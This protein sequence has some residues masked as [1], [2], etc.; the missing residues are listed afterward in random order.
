MEIFDSINLYLLNHPI[1]IDQLE[2]AIR[3]KFW[4]FLVLALFFLSLP[5]R[6]QR[7]RVKEQAELSKKTDRFL[8]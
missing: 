5:Y 4:V 7:K 1:M 3:I 6:E 8:A 2:F